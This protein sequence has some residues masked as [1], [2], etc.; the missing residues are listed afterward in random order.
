MFAD[1]DSDIKICRWTKEEDDTLK[2]AVELNAGRNWK[3]I[4]DSLD[5]RNATQCA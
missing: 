2:N 1:I 3:K 4:S 5:G